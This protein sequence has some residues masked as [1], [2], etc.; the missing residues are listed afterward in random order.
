MYLHGTLSLT[1]AVEYMYVIVHVLFKIH[2]TIHTIIVRVV[3]M[4]MY[5]LRTVLKPLARFKA[6]QVVLKP[7]GPL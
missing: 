7:S 4:H 5:M 6:V 3:Y 2:S 1:E